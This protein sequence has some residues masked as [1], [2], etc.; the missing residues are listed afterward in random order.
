MKKDGTALCVAFKNMIDKAETELGV[1][2]VALC[3]DNDGGSQR[4]RKDLVAERKWV[5]G[6]PCCAH[7]V[8]QV[9]RFDSG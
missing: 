2:I 6:V 7:Q 9:Q 3:C 5:F 1:I 4:A 8:C